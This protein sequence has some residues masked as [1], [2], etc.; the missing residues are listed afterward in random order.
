MLETIETYV[1]MFFIYSFFGW[2]MESVRVSI[3]EKKWVDRGFLIGPVLP[4]YGWGVVLVTIFLKKYLDDI[5]VTFVMSIVICGLLEYFTSFFMEKIFKARWWD[6]SNRKF[7]INGRICLENLFLFGIAC[8]LI[9]YIA[10]P[11]VYSFIEWLPDLLKHISIGI[12]GIIYV[13]DSIVST[14]LIFSL[15]KVSS[16]VKDN[17]R[18][19]SAKVKNII[20]SKSR[21]HRRLVD[22]FPNIRERV[23]YT[24]WTIKNKLEE[25]SNKINDKVEEVQDKINERVEDVNNKINKKKKE[26]QEKIDKYKKDVKE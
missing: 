6:Y 23:D 19:I 2:I 17:T 21:F 24:K 1:L 25:V 5:L 3:A 20:H 26:V 8:C 18:E 11:L 13:A 12:F 10:N 7:N 4:I 15:K 16:E 22:A 9:V 14:V